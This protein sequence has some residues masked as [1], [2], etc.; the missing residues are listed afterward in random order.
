MQKQILWSVVAAGLLAA[1]AAGCGSGGGKRNTQSVLTSAGVPGGGPPTFHAGHLPTPQ[2]SLTVTPDTTTM[3]GINGGSTTVTVSGSAPI[4]TVYVAMMD[5]D[6]YWALPIPAGQTVADVLLTL[7][8]KLD[9]P[10]LTVQ[11]EVVD[12]AG[13]VSQPV[14]ITITVITVGTGDVQ[15]SLS[16]DKSEDI[17][18]HVVDPDGSEIYWSQ[19]GSPS[20]GMLDLD[21]NAACDVDNKNNENIRW[22]TGT[23]PRG[24]YTVRVDNFENCSLEAVKYVVTVHSGS[25]P[26]QTFMGSFAADDL[27]DAGGAGDGVP[28]TTFTFP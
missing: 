8:T 4:V 26:A 11:I 2:G 19:P 5:L 3:M 20:S 17:D 22:P 7:A 6:G 25:R 15:V 27:G 1:A 13:N 10:V 18:L 24:T 16:W 12:A 14:Y 21:S 23:A 9:M 28:V